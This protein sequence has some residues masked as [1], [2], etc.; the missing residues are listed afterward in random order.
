MGIISD[1]RNK[2]KN[3]ITPKFTINKEELSSLLSGEVIQKE[4]ED[5]K[6]KFLIYISDSDLNMDNITKEHLTIEKIK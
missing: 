6:Q 1:I 4:D 3:P 2:A 5:T